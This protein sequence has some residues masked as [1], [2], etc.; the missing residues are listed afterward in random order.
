M[1]RYKKLLVN[2]F[3]PHFNEWEFAKE[4]TTWHLRT[5]ETI[6]VFNIKTSLWSESCH[7]HAGIY[8]R[9]LGAL[10]LPAET[11]CHIRTC[12]P[13][14][15]FHS[16]SVAR[17]NELLDFEHIGFNAEERI[18]KLK[19]LIYPLAFEWFARFHDLASAKRELS[20]IE[21]PW[22]PISNAVWPMIGLEPPKENDLPD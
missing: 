21:R 19:N 15:K 14:P 5:P 12:I 11:Y 16:E 22:F 1:A 10:D 17:I 3:K 7:F 2:S 18:T 9:A 8:F 6:H 4:D 13:D 20:A